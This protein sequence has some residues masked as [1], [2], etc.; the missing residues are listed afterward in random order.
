[1]STRDTE[2]RRF[3]VQSLKEYLQKQKQIEQQLR[4]SEEC[5]RNLLEFSPE[6][7]AVHQKGRVVYINPAGLRLMGSDSKEEIIGRPILDFVHPGYRDVV[8]ER[9]RKIEKNETVE[10]LE[11]KLIRSDGQVIDI[12]VLPVRITYMGEPAV[13]LICRDITERK[14]VE[15][16]LRERDA[17]Y[18]I[19][20][21]H[22]TDL[23][24]VLDIHGIVTYISPSY[25]TIL[26]DPPEYCMGKFLFEK[27]HPEDLPRAKR[28]FHEMIRTKTPRQ[29]E[30]RY[31]HADGHWIT[32]EANGAPVIEENGEVSKIVF[33]ARDITERKRTEE[34]L[35]KADKLSLVGELAAGVAHE[36][37]NPL[38]ALK[39]FVQLL[40]AKAENHPDYKPEY[41]EIML[42]ELDRIH[43]I[44]NEFMLLAKPQVSNFQPKDIRILMQHV[45]ALLTTQAIMNDVQIRTEFESDIPL[46]TCEEN[47]LKQVFVNI[48]KNAIEAMPN[49]GDLMIQMKMYSSEK[50]LIRFVDQGCGIPEELIP[51][52][53]NPFFT[54][55]EQGTGLG[56]MVC[57]KIIETHQGCIHIS[58]EK[59]KGTTVD[60]ILPVHVRE[61][62]E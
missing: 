29:A 17:N 48:L 12:E 56:L 28:L 60:I 7:I 1:M 22:M 50:V 62:R 54:T 47:Q 33:V 24:G 30:L 14:R 4:E 34:L 45:V 38:T 13:L 43:F 16:A 27:V 52:L 32:M 20:E 37:R 42:S 10:I 55:K 18:R 21:Q 59:D 61:V 51:K 46:V 9:V 58:S 53:G 57:Y 35:R 44:V 11:E 6:P 5:Y 8:A 41:F 15:Q 40:Q 25:Q 23:I 2:G 26:G 19:I 49:G 3:R 36:I 39:G 31:K